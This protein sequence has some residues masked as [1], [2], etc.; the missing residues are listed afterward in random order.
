M[1]FSSLKFIG[2]NPTQTSGMQLAHSVEKRG[3][4]VNRHFRCNTN[5]RLMQQNK[6]LQ[7]YKNTAVKNFRNLEMIRA[8]NE[9]LIASKGITLYMYRE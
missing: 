9:R 3:Q 1:Q 5:K 2:N 4:Y 7:G 8:T 6:F